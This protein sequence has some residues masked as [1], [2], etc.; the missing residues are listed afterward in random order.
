MKLR[1]MSKVTTEIFSGG[2]VPLKYIPIKRM[3]LGISNSQGANTWYS[4]GWYEIARSKLIGLGIGGSVLFS[5]GGRVLI[6]I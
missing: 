6:S 1:E 5:A 4:L 3:M 2:I